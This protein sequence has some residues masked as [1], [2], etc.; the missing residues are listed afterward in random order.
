MAEQERIAAHLA[1]R[2]FGDHAEHLLQLAD[3]VVQR[4]A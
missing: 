2:A 1:L 4:K 3:L